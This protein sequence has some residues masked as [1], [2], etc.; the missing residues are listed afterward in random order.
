M[1]VS[2]DI[3]PFFKRKKKFNHFWAGTTL[4]LFTPF[5]IIVGYWLF[6]YSF[7]DLYG[8]FKLHIL[9]KVLSP[10]ISLCVVPNLGLFFI[11]INTERFKSGR[12]MILS[13][14]LYGLLIIYLKVYVEKTMF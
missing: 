5:I 3:E 8:F 13:S 14:I 2:K 4:G 6:V 12:G 10:L 1:D 7:L 9:G 11:F